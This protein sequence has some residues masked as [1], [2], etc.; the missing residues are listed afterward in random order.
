MTVDLQHAIDS[1]YGMTVVALLFLP[2]AHALRAPAWTAALAALGAMGGLNMFRPSTV[3]EYGVE[4][5]TRIDAPYFLV[6]VG[7]AALACVVVS[8][9]AFRYAIVWQVAAVGFLI[10]LWTT[11]APAIYPLMAVFTCAAIGLFRIHSLRTSIAFYSILAVWLMFVVVALHPAM[12]GRTE[13]GA[14]VQH[15]LGLALTPVLGG[16]ALQLGAALN[17]RM[18]D[19]H[20]DRVRKRAEREFSVL[21]ERLWP[22]TGAAA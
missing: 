22:V 7:T 16:F 3:F 12:W 17:R 19:A 18:V 9:F 6:A 5:Y 13:L 4:P 21:V 15:N 10:L 1:V 2:L 8:K 20:L 14:L 11:P